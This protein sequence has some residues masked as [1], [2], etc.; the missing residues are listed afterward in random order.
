[1]FSLFLKSLIIQVCAPSLMID[2]SNVKLEYIHIEISISIVKKNETHIMIHIIKYE[3][4]SERHH[5]GH[6]QY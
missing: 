4:E 5:T 2:I 6:L 3:T 1:M